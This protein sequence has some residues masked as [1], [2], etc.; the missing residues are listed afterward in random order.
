MNEALESFR[1]SR[2]DRLYKHLPSA[3][4]A[5]SPGEEEAAETAEDIV[6]THAASGP[7]NVQ[8]VTP[9]FIHQRSA[10]ANAIPSRR[11]MNSA[12]SA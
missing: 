6:D 7:D 1:E 12:G 10:I 9:L 3:P 8:E 5:V 11:T 4:N 2:L